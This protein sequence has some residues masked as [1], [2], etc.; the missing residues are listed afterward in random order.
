MSIRL[1]LA[2]LLAATLV[3]CSST[4]KD[5]EQNQTAKTPDL[6]LS[7]E[8]PEP[9][10]PLVKAR[11][12]KRI[13]DIRYQ[14]GVTLVANLERI[15]G[16]GDVAIP[17][18]MDGLKS[19]DPMTRMGCAWVLGRVG[20]TAAIPALEDALN[21][22]VPYVRYEVA[23]QIGVLGGKGGYKTLVQGLTDE[24]VEMRFKCFE[25]LQELTGNTF[26]YSHTAAPEVRKVAVEQWE[27]WVER[28]DTEDM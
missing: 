5:D 7:K 14:R 18:A 27:A 24:R 8:F 15:A 23:S 11:L 1:L 10:N 25:A 21:D 2:A 22:P 17:F 16:Y 4:P 26:G 3:A 12:E 19:E 20:N 28:V 6:D 13:T 9:S